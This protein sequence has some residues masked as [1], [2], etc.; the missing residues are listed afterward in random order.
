MGE[1]KHEVEVRR[2]DDLFPAFINPEFPV[3][4]LT[5]GTEAAAAGIV[6]DLD[7]STV[8][9]LGSVYPQPSGLAGKDRAGGLFLD[10]GQVITRR[11][12]IG[13]REG[14]DFLDQGVSHP[15][16]LP[17]SQRD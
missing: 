15:N 9:A 4:G 11:K 12:E 2:I 7:M 17:D 8:R 5:G 3:H 10:I 1:G 13:I 16:H 14:P 6:M